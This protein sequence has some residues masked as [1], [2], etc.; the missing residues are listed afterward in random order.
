V[1]ADFPP[2]DILINPVVGPEAVTGSTRMKAGT[3]TKMVLNMIST[4]AMVKLGKVYG[5]LM[6]DVQ[7]R[8]LKLARRAKMILQEVT[9]IDDDE[10]SEL[11]KQA[12]NNLKVA[13]IMKKLSV[14]PDKASQIL[15][16]SHASLRDA[17]ETGSK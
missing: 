13:I 15:A 11:M 1:T 17:L 8:S 2:A 4:G 10:A 3:A 6:V 14:G 9:R 5:N 12:S 7:P 16:E